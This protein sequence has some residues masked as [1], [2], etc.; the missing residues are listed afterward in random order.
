MGWVSMLL[1]PKTA[2]AV[3]KTI[4]SVKGMYN[5]GASKKIINKKPEVTMKNSAFE[6]KQSSKKFKESADKVFK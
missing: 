3:S 2:G 6:A 1:N 4:S 5:K